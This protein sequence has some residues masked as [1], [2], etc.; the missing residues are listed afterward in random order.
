MIL[1]LILVTLGFAVFVELY[2]GS[3]AFRKNSQNETTFRLSSIGSFLIHPF[4]N[5]FLWHPQLWVV[6]YPLVIGIA[7][8]I[9]LKFDSLTTLVTKLNGVSQTTSQDTTR[10]NVETSNRDIISKGV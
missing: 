5:R 3:I 10:T 4:H 7:C 1:F 8:L 2:V 6:N 9:Y